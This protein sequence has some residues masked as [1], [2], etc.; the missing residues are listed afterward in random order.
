MVM[1]NKE[2]FALGVINNII[3]VDENNVIF[4]IGD[5]VRDVIYKGDDKTGAEIFLDFPGNKERDILEK[6]L[7]SVR[8]EKVTKSFFHTS[9]GKRIVIFPAN[10]E[11]ENNVVI[12]FEDEIADAN[13]ISS[14]LK[15]RVKEIQCLYSISHEINVAKTLEEVFENTSDH[16]R[17]GFQFPDLTSVTI[18]F[19][20]KSYGDRES[21][22]SKISI[23]EKII[24]EGEER[25]LI[26]ISLNGYGKFLEEEY[27][28]IKEIGDSFS[29][30]IERVE[31]RV[32]L[33]K[34]K[35]ILERKNLKLLDLTEECARNREELETL[36]GAITDRIYVVEKNGKM[37]MSNNKDIGDE[38]QK[39]ESLCKSELKNKKSP[40]M[41]VFD[42][43]KSINFEKKINNLYFSIRVYPIFSKKGQV[44]KILVMCRNVTE[45]KE[46]ENQMLQSNK[47]AS[48]G[49][50]VA[51]IAHEINNPN[52]FIRGNL[53][54]IKESF[55]DIF[56]IIDKYYEEKSDLMIARLNYSI[57][58]EN[59]PF[60]IND[61]FEGSNRI[62]KIVDDLRNYARKDEGSLT[63]DV[64][65]NMVIRNAFRL[66]ESQIR[67]MAQVKLHLHD[68]LPVFKGNFQKLE[69]VIVN[70]ILN[71]AQSIN[72]QRGKVV[73]NSSCSQ[74]GKFVE[75]VIADNGKGIDEDIVNLIFDPFFT[76]KRTKGGTGLGLSISYGIIKEHGGE[77]NVLS[78]SGEGTEFTITL[79][80]RRDLTNEKYTC[81]R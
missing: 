44:E 18:K 25:G 43:G 65:I 60:L 53:K 46:L 67:R 61:M 24:V 16:M 73:I 62:K 42:V 20:R 32:D 17:N 8:G 39:F 27:D 50:L 38:E 74:D 71:A 14:E 34:K 7:N 48:L 4:F 66:V 59:I 35:L 11:K 3:V 80:V 30:T 56:P 51:G 54:I 6:N 22:D 47:L 15:E 19:D 37:S 31:S 78:K 29:K 58:K 77:I 68:K 63:D 28:L 55:D 10:H 36:I 1:H 75:I 45:K 64:D 69:Q 23:E 41:N 81:S 76:T 33:E 49:K 57:F 2:S 9:I 40:I 12:F 26:K 5:T 79:P 13:I 21:D 52:T 72:G 70:M